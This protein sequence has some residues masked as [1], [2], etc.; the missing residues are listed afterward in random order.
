MD[1]NDYIG[2]VELADLIGISKQALYYRASRKGA[3]VSIK[4]NRRR[5]FRRDEALNSLVLRLP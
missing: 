1:P 2:L 3:P 4:V 5:Y